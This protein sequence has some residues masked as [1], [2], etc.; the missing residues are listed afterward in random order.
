MNRLFKK[1]EKETGLVTATIKKMTGYVEPPPP[2]LTWYQKLLRFFLNL[3]RKKRVIR[4]SWVPDSYTGLS[5]A[6]NEWLTI[7]WMQVA[8]GHMRTWP[9]PFG[10][11]V[12][13]HIIRKWVLQHEHLF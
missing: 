7:K 2:P 8:R 5:V 3:F 1:F 4:N 6:F 10:E 9:H 13:K 12:N 11:R